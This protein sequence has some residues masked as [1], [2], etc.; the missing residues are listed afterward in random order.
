MLPPNEERIDVVNS[1][2]GTML[3]EEITP[4][5]MVIATPLVE[6]VCQKNKLNLVEIL[7]PYCSFDN[8]DGEYLLLSKISLLLRHFSVFNE[9]QARFFLGIFLCI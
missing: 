1:P 8:I 7:Q 4:V 2:L 5:I 9:A 3:L 6:E